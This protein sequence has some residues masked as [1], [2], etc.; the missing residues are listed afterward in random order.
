MAD[1]IDPL[2]ISD[3]TGWCMVWKFDLRQGAL[4]RE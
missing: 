2:K 1:P 3:N 4:D